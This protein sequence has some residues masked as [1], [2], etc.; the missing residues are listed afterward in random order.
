MSESTHT[1][2]PWRWELNPS[3]RDIRLIGGKIRHDLSVL[4]FVRWGRNGAAPAFRDCSP[5]NDRLQ[6]MARADNYGVVAP[7][8]EHH[9]DWFRLVDHP[10]ARLIAAAPDLLAACEEGERL[11][12]FHRGAPNRT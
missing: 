7:G 1:P 4:Q 10:D 6:I 12:A 9:A 3:A 5:E 8:R 11:L 2:G